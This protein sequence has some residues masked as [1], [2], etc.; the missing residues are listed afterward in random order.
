MVS[1]KNPIKNKK[2]INMK[3]NQQQRQ[4]R[5]WQKSQETLSLRREKEDY[6]RSFK[7]TAQARKRFCRG[8]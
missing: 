4:Q 8:F 6:Y 7:I 3:N 5:A 2:V 1:L